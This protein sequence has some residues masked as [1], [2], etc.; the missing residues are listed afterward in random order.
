MDIDP[1][2]LLDRVMEATE[3]GEVEL[4]SNDNVFLR[5]TPEEE[6]A[7]HGVLAERFAE[8]TRRSRWK[9]SSGLLAEGVTIEPGIVSTDTAAAIIARLTE[10]RQLD[11]TGFQGQQISASM[12]TQ[13][14]FHAG[15]SIEDGGG[16]HRWL[17]ELSTAS[18]GLAASLRCFNGSSVTW[19]S[20]QIAWV[21]PTARELTTWSHPALPSPGSGETGTEKDSGWHVGPDDGLAQELP[22]DEASWWT[23]RPKIELV[24]PGDRSVV[25]VAQHPRGQAVLII[26]EIEE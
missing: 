2:E 26:E 22:I 9:V 13:Q 4:G 16:S 25:L 1:G 18:V 6:Q 21:D 10:S 3:G 24:I 11:L 14:E 8:R 23:W 17:P 15:V 7:I 5:V 20:T 12:G 19:L